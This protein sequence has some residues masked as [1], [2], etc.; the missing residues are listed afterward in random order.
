MY[1]AHQTVTIFGII[2]TLTA[3]LFGAFGAHSLQNVFPQEALNSIETGIR[4]Q[5]YHGLA[6]LILPTILQQYKIDKPWIARC[7]ISGIAM[8]SGSIYLIHILKFFQLS[9][10]FIV[11]MTPVGGSLLLIG[12]TLL[13]LKVVKL[14]ST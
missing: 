14:K 8:F 7:W 3:V 11:W 5:F 1:K 9:P 13:L 4:Y 2:C 10:I 12:W 6:L